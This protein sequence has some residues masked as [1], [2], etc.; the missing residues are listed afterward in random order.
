VGG[1]LLPHV[2]ASCPGVCQPWT[3]CLVLWAGRHTTEGQRA[4][5][6]HSS[7]QLL[8]LRWPTPAAVLCCTH[9]A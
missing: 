7:L 4:M 2:P 5:A 1:P 8:S 3:P 9:S 6:R